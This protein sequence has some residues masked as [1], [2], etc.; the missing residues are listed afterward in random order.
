MVIAKDFFVNNNSHLN[1]WELLHE[2]KKL[3]PLFYA[4]FLTFEKKF[5]PC[6]KVNTVLCSVAGL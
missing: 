5:S 1:R 4:V 3:Y 2:E 6:V